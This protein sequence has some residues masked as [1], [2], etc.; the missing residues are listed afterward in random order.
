MD[1]AGS[2]WED[3]DLGGDQ[4]ELGQFET[5]I[6]WSVD[7]SAKLSKT[8]ISSSETTARKAGDTAHDSSPPHAAD[9]AKPLEQDYPVLIF[10]PKIIQAAKNRRQDGKHVPTL[11][12]QQ[13]F[14][15]FLPKW[16]AYKLQEEERKEAMLGCASPG[17]NAGLPLPSNTSKPRYF[18]RKLAPSTK[19]SAAA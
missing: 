4:L 2:K 10:P 17:L 14:D 3:Q 12:M 11:E 8:P 18:W 13:E 19:S 15:N 1:H 6:T 16:T 9:S 7:T 5:G